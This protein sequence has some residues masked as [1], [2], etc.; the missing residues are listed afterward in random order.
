MNRHQRLILAAGVV[1]AA[2]LVVRPPYFGVDRASGGRT[3]A[4][5]GLHWAWDPP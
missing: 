3:H 4:A 2:V 1:M 5:I